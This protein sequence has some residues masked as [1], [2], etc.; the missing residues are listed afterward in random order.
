MPFAPTGASWMLYGT[1]PPVDGISI[2]AQEH[3]DVQAIDA[4]ALRWCL[5]AALDGHKQQKEQCNSK[6]DLHV[7]LKLASEQCRAVVP[8]GFEWSAQPFIVLAGD[9][10]WVPWYEPTY[11]D[12][13]SSARLV[14]GVRLVRS[15]GAPQ[16]YLFEV[17]RN[18]RSAACHTILCSVADSCFPMLWLY[19]AAS[20]FGQLDPSQVSFVEME[21]AAA[22][23]RVAT[24]FGDDRYWPPYYAST[25]AG[26]EKLEV[27][28][29]GWAETRAPGEVAVQRPPEGRSASR[30]G[31]ALPEEKLVL[32]PG[33]TIR[34][35]YTRGY[36]LKLQR[37][38]K[39][40]SA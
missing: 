21:H 16:L 13:N 30:A 31:A 24:P 9:T 15:R 8:D 35:N 6:M 28:L 39:R 34:E 2:D 37:K 19:C 40:D 22:L 36:L 5:N 14:T 27:A 17:S 1:V 23:D 26:L 11:Q 29:L 32:P 7:K 12:F 20:K 18:K 33:F 10:V 3:A 4:P 25:A 38:R